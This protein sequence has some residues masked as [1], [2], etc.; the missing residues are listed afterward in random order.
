M[1]G[2]WA[3]M[4]N[5]CH[6]ENN[7]AFGRYGAVGTIVCDRWRFGDGDKIG[8]VCFLEDMGERPEGMTLDRHP[9]PAGN[10]EPSNCRW[11]TIQEQRNNRTV[12]GDQRMR[13]ASRAS[14]LAYWR[15]R[16]EL[17]EAL[18]VTAEPVNRNEGKT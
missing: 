10:Y 16:R 13:E 7:S 3:G 9:N 8:F 14:R 5:R 1:Y 18:F 12:A 11:A 17:Y 6:N 15:R 2:A 4:V